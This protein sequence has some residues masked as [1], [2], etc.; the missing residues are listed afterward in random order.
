MELWISQLVQ[1]ISHLGNNAFNLS[2]FTCHWKTKLNLLVGKQWVPNNETVGW[3]VNVRK[4]STEFQNYI[5]WYDIISKQSLRKHVCTVSSLHPWYLMQQAI[6]VKFM[7]LTL[8]VTGYQCLVQKSWHWV[9]QAISDQLTSPDTGCNRLSVSSSQVLTL[10]ATGYQCPVHKPD[11]ECNKLLVSSSPAVKMGTT[12]CQCPV[13]RPW[14]WVQ[15]A[16]DA[17]CNRPSVVNNGKHISKGIKE[18]N[19]IKSEISNTSAFFFFFFP[20]F[21][22]RQSSWKCWVPKGAHF[23]NKF[24]LFQ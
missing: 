1:E 2:G 17:E 19:F 14:G 6:S 8:G 12:S 13:H 16:T 15:Q 11:T 5:F 18:C 3:Y 9:Q 4:T 7:N 21:F 23:R 22:A 20:F 24:S 10:G